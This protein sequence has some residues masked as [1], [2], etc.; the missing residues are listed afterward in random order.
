[1]HSL[2]GWVKVKGLELDILGVHLLVLCVLVQDALE[3]VVV[4]RVRQQPR[5]LLVTACNS[6]Q[7]HLN[8]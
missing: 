8:R 4:A 6:M 5:Q 3:L 7:S 1:M 2:S